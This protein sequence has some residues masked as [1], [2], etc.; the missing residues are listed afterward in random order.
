[1]WKAWP[2]ISLFDQLTVDRRF[3]L[4]RLWSNE[5]LRLIGPFVEGEVVNVSAWRDD[6]KQGGHYRDYFP[7]ATRY[8][9]TNYGGYRGDGIEDS[10]RLDLESPLPPELLRRFDVVFNH[11]TLEHVFNVFQA[12]ENLCRMSREAVIVVVPAVQEEH[13][14]DTFSDY[15]RFTSGGL[16]ALFERNGLSIAIL[17]SSPFCNAAVY[18]LIVATRQTGKW[19]DVSALVQYPVN[20]GSGLVRESWPIAL[21]RNVV[22]RVRRHG[23]DSR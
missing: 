13:T 22:R 4:A 3:R 9:T 15:W 10:F 11:T 23:R 12:T 6:D 20:D 19:K 21:V 18:H 8:Y 17:T 2:R 16:S 7:N 14:S 1:M 5:V